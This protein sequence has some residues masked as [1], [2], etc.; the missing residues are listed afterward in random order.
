MKK[1]KWIKRTIIIA[2]IAA[3]IAIPVIMSLNKPAD[4][5]YDSEVAKT[6]DITTYYS[7][8]GEIAA[9]EKREMMAEGSYKITK[10]HVKEGDVVASGD[11]LYEIDN[12]NMQAQ[13]DQ[14]A[15]AVNVAQASYNATSGSGAKQQLSSAQNALESAKLGYQNAGKG[16]AEQQLASAESAVT[17]AESAVASAQLAV[18]N[19]RDA[20]DKLKT[21]FDAGA[22]AKSELDSAQAQLD[23][24]ENQMSLAKSQRDSANKNVTLAKE[25][26]ATSRE[27]SK[28]QLDQAQA[29]YNL[30]KNSVIGSS[31]DTAKA[32]L[33]QARASYEAIKTQMT[34][35]RVTAKIAGEITK[36]YA[37]ENTT[38]MAGSPVL[39]IVDYATLAA[40]VK[41]DEYDVSAI[42][43]GKKVAVTISPLSRDIEGTVVRLTRETDSIKAISYF[44]AKI[45]LPN[46]KD[47]LEG[48]SVEVRSKKASTEG[49]VTISMKALQFDNENKPYVDVMDK[50]KK[51][52]RR[53]V[54]IG[55]NDGLSVE[56]KSGLKAGETVYMKKQIMT[57]PMPAAGGKAG[58]EAK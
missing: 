17:S 5:G 8:S 30:I 2:V 56:I 37:D 9:Q 48:M 45:E 55:I 41:V 16:A 3:I 32:Q 51:I 46:D 27:A 43:A 39:D 47:L 28:L 34:E 53:S 40:E 50:D 1:R 33:D 13:L 19:A 49:A 12:D 14:A 36:I 31:Q 25:A 42:Q 15:A 44:V 52:T 54:E 22:I 24:A 20:R 11:V 7:F 21:L 26:I 35:S 57:M 18:K 10:M 4:I 6:S 58:G 38:V 29:N 23:Q